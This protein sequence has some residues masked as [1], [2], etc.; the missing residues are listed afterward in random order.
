MKKY[1]SIF[2]A[3]LI[4]SAIRAQAQTETWSYSDCVEYAR[5]HNISLKKSRLA[6]ETSAYNLDEAKAQWQP[7]LDFSTSHNLSNYPWKKGNKNLYNS[8]YGLNAEWTVWNGGQRENTIKRNKLQTEIDRLSTT[9]AMR[10]IET[11]LLQVYLNI[12]Y[13]K[14]SIGIYEESTALSKK[15]ADRAEQLM[16]AGRLSKV[17]YAQLTSQYEQDMYALVNAKGTYNTR[18]MELKKLLELGIDSDIELQEVQW[19]NEKILTDLPSIDESYKLAIATDT[20]IKG[21]EL[22]KKGSEIDIEIAKASGKPQLSL[23]AGIGTGYFAPGGNFKSGLKQE[24]NE[25]I[26]LT[27]AIPILNNK[28]TSTAVAKAKVQRLD[29]QL[30]IEQRNTDLAQAVENW[31]IDTRSSQSRYTA[32]MQQLSA[33]E[34]SNELTNEQFNLG[35]VNTVEL[36]TAHNNLVEAQHTLLQAKY[37]SILGHKMIEF[38]RTATITLP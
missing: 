18:R 16:L 30:D 20:Y 24:W 9:T 10:S 12:L 26:G 36:M 14:E 23:N 22:E 31:Y 25:N 29:A 38:Y 3:L 15:Q 11:E 17:D 21:L 13:A 6:E 5:E 34:L 28:K 33:A 32:A 37:M 35:L 19:D 4:S 8:N 7:S 27:I 1:V 2:T